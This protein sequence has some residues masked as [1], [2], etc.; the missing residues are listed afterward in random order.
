MR[1]QQNEWNNRFQKIFKNQWTSEILTCPDFE[2]LTDWF[3]RKNRD[4]TVYLQQYLLLLP[5]RSV[6][7]QVCLI[8]KKFIPFQ[9]GSVFY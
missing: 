4:D 7:I 9:S 2:L 5:I 8:T 1:L 6:T 3:A